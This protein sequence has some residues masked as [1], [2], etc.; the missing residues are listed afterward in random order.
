MCKWLWLSGA[1]KFNIIQLGICIDLEIRKERNR[2][3]KSLQLKRT[4]AVKKK[5]RK[6]KKTIYMQIKVYQLYLY[7]C[8]S[9]M[10]LHPH[11][12]KHSCK[13]ERLY[14]HLGRQNETEGVWGERL[15]QR[16]AER[17]ERLDPPVHEHTWDSC[18]W[19]SMKWRQTAE[20]QAFAHRSQTDRTTG[21]LFICS[22]TWKINTSSLMHRDLQAEIG[23]NNPV[24]AHSHCKSLPLS[25][26]AFLHKES[27]SIYCRV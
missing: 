14:T 3:T 20:A 18:M 4:L 12:R 19:Q 9:L 8:C 24:W 11:A 15:R 27:V 16:Q 1:S 23:R 17:D 2:D 7:S 25:P 10:H 13:Q 5:W 6:E 22:Q 26:S 21:P